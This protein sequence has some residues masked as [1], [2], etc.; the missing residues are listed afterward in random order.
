MSSV[1]HKRFRVSAVALDLDG[2]LLDT[3]PDIA[4]AAD[5]MLAD[6]GRPAAGEARVRG[7]IGRGIPRLV[8][9]LLTGELHDEPDEAAF[10]RALPLFEQHYRETFAERSRP[11][12]GVVEG[13]ER[14]RGAGLR[15]ACVTNKAASFTLPLLAHTGLAGF[16]DLVVSGDSLP[17]KKPDPLPLQHIAQR[18]GVAPAELLLIGDSDN[19]TEAARAAGCPV[20]CVPYGYPGEREVRDLDC[21]A[22][23][24]SLIEAVGLIVPPQS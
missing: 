1:V 3:L 16:F 18:F 13:I 9:R 14:M 21:D 15:L 11:F 19:D 12:P 5:R 6:L 8:K 17:R 20:V 2:T 23:V 22:I 10:E 24:P 7:Y 4:Q